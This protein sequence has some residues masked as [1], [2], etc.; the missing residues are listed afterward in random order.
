MEVGRYIYGVIGTDEEKSFG[1]IGIGEKGD[2][3]YTI[4]YQNIAAVISNS[5]IIDYKSLTK[6]IVVRYL[7]VHQLVVEKVMKE[8]TV[9][10]VKFGTIF[11]SVEETENVLEKGYTIFKDSI[12][13]LKDKIEMDIIV[14]WNK[15]IIF[16]DIAND[17]KIKRFKQ[18]IGPN[19]SESDKIRLGKMVEGILSEKKTRY[20][21]KIEDDLCKCAERFS[22][23]ETMDSSMIANISLLMNKYKEKELDS[24]LDE[25]NRKYEERVNFKCVGPLPA[26]SFNTIEIKK[27]EFGLIDRARKKLS[28]G[29]RVTKIEIRDAYRQLVQKYHPDKSLG[30]E[31]FKEITQAYKTLVEYCQ[32]IMCSFKEAEVRD[33]VVIKVLNKGLDNDR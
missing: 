20:A 15:D 11:S 18:D 24:K 28:L 23:H 33:A 1:T 31:Q 7:Y 4:P 5:P 29:E 27:P 6:D 19:S 12:K 16:K 13:T 9:I 26:Y 25:L 3:V 21:K 22:K 2:E 30:D 32:G 10:P 8:F 17:E 14:L